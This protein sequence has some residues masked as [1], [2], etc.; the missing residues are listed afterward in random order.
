M[1]VAG[2]ISDM[3]AKI[4]GLISDHLTLHEGYQRPI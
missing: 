1:P 4:N 3:A 2:K